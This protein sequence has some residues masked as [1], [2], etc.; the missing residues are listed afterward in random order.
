MKDF[1][2]NHA[3]QALYLAFLA[4]M[5]LYIAVENIRF[6]REAEK[7]REEYERLRDQ[8]FTKRNVNDI[9]SVTRMVAAHNRKEV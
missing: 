6:N 4:A 3:D 9:G 2:V 8:W 5:I 7:D 1:L